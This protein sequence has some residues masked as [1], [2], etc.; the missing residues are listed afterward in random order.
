MFGTNMQMKFIVTNKNGKV[1]AHIFVKDLYDDE[2]YEASA[3]G[4]DIEEVLT[5]LYTDLLE[6]IESQELEEMDEDDYIDY[7]ENRIEELEIECETLREENKK[8]NKSYAGTWSSNEDVD[9]FLE[10]YFSKYL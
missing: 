3:S 7:L 5:D 8:K 9:K 10:K 1:D 6:N 2:E 4:E